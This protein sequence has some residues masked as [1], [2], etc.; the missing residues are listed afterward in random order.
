[1]GSPEN[2]VKLD[3]FIAGVDEAT[4]KA[5][6][7]NTAIETAQARAV[8]LADLLKALKVDVK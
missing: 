2:E 8:E 5:E 4:E 6:A 3:V 7:L 1:M